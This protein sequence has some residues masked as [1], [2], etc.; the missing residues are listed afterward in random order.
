MNSKYLRISRSLRKKTTPRHNIIKL[1]KT[2]DKS[3]NGT[4]SFYL[5]PIQVNFRQSSLKPSLSIPWIK[6]FSS[7]VIC[8][9]APVSPSPPSPSPS[10]SRT[11]SIISH[12]QYFNSLT[13][14]S[15]VS[16]ITFLPSKNIH[17]LHCHQN[18]L[19]T[20]QT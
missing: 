1:L 16:L 17:S 13:G 15:D 19:Q 3:S 6:K 10:E 4:Y 8:K 7:Q 5:T 12:F 20:I 2:R 18:N 11:L 14:L 9:L